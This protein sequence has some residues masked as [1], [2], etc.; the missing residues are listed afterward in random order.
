MYGNFRDIHCLIDF[1]KVCWSSEDLD[2]SIK[3]ALK[4]W[5]KR[6]KEFSFIKK[7]DNLG[8][9]SYKKRMDY[10]RK[11]ITKQAL[12]KNNNDFAQAAKYLE[13]SERTLRNNMDTEE[14]N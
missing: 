8:K 1:I 2:N 3:E 11:A 12:E 4:L 13:V 14:S 7:D 6:Q 9:G 5:N 10:F